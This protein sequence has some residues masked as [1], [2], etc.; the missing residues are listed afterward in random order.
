MTQLSIFPWNCYLDRPMTGAVRGVALVRV[1][2]GI[3]NFQAEGGELR[4]VKE[5]QLL[6]SYDLNLPGEGMKVLELIA[7]HAE[8]YGW[9]QKDNVK[10]PGTGKAPSVREAQALG[11][12]VKRGLVCEDAGRWRV[13]DQG[14]RVLRVWRDLNRRTS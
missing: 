3:V 4:L 10:L 7:G 5:E 2:D 9:Q 14:K 13:T 1:R 11:A 12:L 8:G 6:T